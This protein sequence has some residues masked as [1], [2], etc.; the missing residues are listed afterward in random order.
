V[1]G[2]VPTS[3]VLGRLRLPPCRSAVQAAAAML[4]TAN[5]HL[6]IHVTFLPACLPPAA[7][8]GSPSD[9]ATL[10]EPQSSSLVLA[11]EA[12]SVAHPSTVHGAF[13]SGQEA[14]Y[15]VLDAARELP[16][17]GTSSSGGLGSGGGACVLPPLEA[18][19]TSL[20]CDCEQSGAPP[21]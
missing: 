9:R 6:C 13:L 11:G 10:A 3:A 21:L 1:H 2:C 5:R 12:A 14:A 20:Q 18:A 19:A 16:Q 17:C 15:R 8:G 4:T 7:V